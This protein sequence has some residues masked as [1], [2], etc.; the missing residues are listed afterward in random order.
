MD[1][2]AAIGT[3]AELAKKSAAP[4]QIKLD[5]ERTLI[6]VNGEVSEYELIPPSNAQTFACYTLNDFA[7]LVLK[8]DVVHPIVFTRDAAHTYLDSDFR[9]IV[10]VSFGK[11]MAAQQ[12]EPLAAESGKFQQRDLLRFL[13]SHNADERTQLAFRSLDFQ[14]LKTASMQRSVGAETLDNSVKAEVR[15]AAN[16][17]TSFYL[18]FAP[19]L[20]PELRGLEHEA[21]IEVDYDINAYSIELWWDE[22]DFNQYQQACSLM[23]RTQLQGLFPDERPVVEGTSKIVVLP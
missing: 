21:R 1:L 19:Y 23:I 16:K 15:D 7:A 9:R 2:A 20:T 3:V 5:D 13:R 12:I 17:P 18:R 8:S 14:V 4:H 10:T 6:V 11:T 22:A